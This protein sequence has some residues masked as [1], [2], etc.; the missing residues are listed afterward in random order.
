MERGFN[1]QDLDMQYQKYNAEKRTICTGKLFILDN[2]FYPSEKPWNS[3]VSRDNKSV[4]R[5]DKSRYG[6]KI[7]KNVNQFSID[8][9]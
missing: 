8:Q 7:I 4:L 5:H 6:L 3:Y 9:D 2:A 1:V